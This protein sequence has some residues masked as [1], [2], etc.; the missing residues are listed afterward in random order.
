MVA[1]NPN[2]NNEEEDEPKWS[3]YIYICVVAAARGHSHESGRL[4]WNFIC[5]LQKNEN[6]KKNQIIFLDFHLRLL[7]LHSCKSLKI[8]PYFKRRN[9]KGC[10]AL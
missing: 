2:P 1:T 9:L 3:T 4:I 10:V 6:P 5:K 8:T 7:T